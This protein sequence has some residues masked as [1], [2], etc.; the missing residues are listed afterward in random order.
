M[1]KE[2]GK[3]ESGISINHYLR[4]EGSCAEKL[5]YG[6]NSLPLATV[7]VLML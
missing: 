3:K 5:F 6:G 1:K 2:K 4:P 7:S